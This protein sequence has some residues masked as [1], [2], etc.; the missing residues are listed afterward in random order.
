MT[1][2]HIRFILVSEIWN[3]LVMRHHQHLLNT[4]MYETQWSKNIK[5]VSLESQSTG[6]YQPVIYSCHGETEEQSRAVPPADV[7]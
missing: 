4:L 2:T 5:H 3:I 1:G 6:I 7:L